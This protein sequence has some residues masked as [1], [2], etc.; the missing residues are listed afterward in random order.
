MSDD[1]DQ[2]PESDPYCAHWISVY[3]KEHAALN[4]RCENCGEPCSSHLPGWG[5]WCH[6]APEGTKDRERFAWKNATWPEG[7]QSARQR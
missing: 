5:A 4:I 7:A 6:N 1:E 2:A 3:D